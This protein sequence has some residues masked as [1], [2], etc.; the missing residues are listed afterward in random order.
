MPEL[1][2]LIRLYIRQVAIGFAISAGFVA[3]LLGFNVAN[4]RHLILSTNGG[5]LAL[6]LLFFFNGLVFAGVQFGIAVMGM[7][8]K[9]RTG[10]GNR[11]ALR[12]PMA[13][14]FA[15]DPVRIPQPAQDPVAYPPKP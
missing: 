8:E 7:A 15:P 4:L 6:F 5:Y 13:D 10:G 1:P 14:A 9:P 12:L 2:A 11:S 3:L